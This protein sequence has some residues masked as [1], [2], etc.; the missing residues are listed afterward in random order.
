MWLRPL[1]PIASNTVTLTSLSDSNAQATSS[2]R[3]INRLPRTRATSFILINSIASTTNSPSQT[4]FYTPGSYSWIAPAGVTSVSVVC[5]GG[6]GNGPKSYN[7]SA[8]GGCGGGLGYKNNIPV[9]PGTSYSVVVGSYGSGHSYGSTNLVGGNSHFISLATVS[10]YGGGHWT[11]GGTGGPNSNGYGGG[12]AGDGGGAGGNTNTSYQAGSGAGGY[13]G[14]GGNRGS[15][16]PAGGGGGSGFEYSSTYG[17]SSGGGVGLLGQAN[18]NAYSGMTPWQTTNGSYGCGGAGSW[19]GPDSTVQD[20]NGTNGN[21]SIGQGRR[22]MY[23]EN[24][25]SSSGEDGNGGLKGGGFGGGGGGQGDSWPGS[26]G[27]GGVGGVRIIW[28]GGTFTTFT[29]NDN[30]LEV[31]TSAVLA[32]SGA[33]IR[34]FPQTNTADL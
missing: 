19:N 8:G 25:W 11:V 31:L 33:V 28:G 24:P 32:S 9:T 23:G 2:I 1:T 15:R 6:G 14:N 17:Y 18:Y 7:S 10:G 26:G 4:L 12:W 3:T 5:V 34:A 22:G 16:T 29:S 27:Q 13:A 20:F 30:D 21:L